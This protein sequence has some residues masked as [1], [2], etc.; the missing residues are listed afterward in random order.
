MLYHLLF[1]LLCF[2]HH[3][4]PCID[5]IILVYIYIFMCHL[6]IIHSYR[7]IKIAG[8][9]LQHFG[10]CLALIMAFEQG[11]DDPYHATSAVTRA[12]DFICLGQKTAELVPFYNKILTYSSPREVHCMKDRAGT[13]YQ[14]C[15]F[16]KQCITL[17][18]K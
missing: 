4:H 6:K 15:A 7:H 9:G 8:E 18:T 2:Q 11:L 14:I 17:K 1:K 12:C 10:L 16:I 3:N 5:W 13:I